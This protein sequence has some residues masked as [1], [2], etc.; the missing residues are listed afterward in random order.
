MTSVSVTEFRNNLREY[1]RLAEYK[2]E[3]INIFDE[4]S[5]KTV[6]TLNPP[7]REKDW[8]EYMKFVNSMFGAW[9]DLP[10]DKNRQR[11]KNAGKR[12]LKR[13]RRI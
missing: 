10:E 8:D 7:K 9:K 3:S 13:L 2:G 12:A 4:K 11:M 5:K 6:A 1:L